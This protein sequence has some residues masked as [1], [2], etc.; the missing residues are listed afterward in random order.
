MTAKR[1]L[2]LLILPLLVG[3]FYALGLQ[4]LL[5][6]ENAKAQQMNLLAFRDAHPLLTISLFPIAYCLM[7]VLPVPLAALTAVI[8]G[9]LYGV[10][11]GTLLIALSAPTGAC[12]GFLTARYLLRREVQTRYAAQVQHINQGLARDGALYLLSLRLVPVLPYF[13]VDLLFGLSNM[14]LR[15][16]FLVGLVG[17]APGALVLTN[18]GRELSQIKSL[19]D[20]FSPTIVL[21]LLAVAA[22]PWVLKLVMRFMRRQNP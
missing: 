20:L 5:S 11:G 16:F 2:P 3:A 19:E 7:G 4:H 10:P 21:S 18:A 9:A 17:M 8:C 22:L 1:W 13:I 15:T 14:R 12:T 6:L